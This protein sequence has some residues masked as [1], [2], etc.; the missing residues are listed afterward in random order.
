MNEKR[1]KKKN[2]IVFAGSRHSEA[3][4]RICCL[5]VEEDCALVYPVNWQSPLCRG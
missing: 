1:R 4:W 5:L 3:L 2:K